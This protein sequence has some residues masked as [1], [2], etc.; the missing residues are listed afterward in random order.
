MEYNFETAP[1]RRGTGAFKW[2]SMLEAKPD[3]SENV[4]PFSVADMEFENP[5]PLLEG[6]AKY[7]SQAVY[8]YTGPTRAYYEAVIGYM[9]RHH[10]WDIEKEWIITT[11]GVVPALFELVQAFTNPGDGIIIMRPVYYPFT[12]AVEDNGRKLVN[13]SLLYR[14]GH[15]DMDFDA[16]EKAAGEPSTKMMIL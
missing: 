4:I 15:Y 1:N 2:N 3:V 16:L 9:K 6:M 12:T 11:P 13:V 8:G 7:V 10:N 5:K 14:N